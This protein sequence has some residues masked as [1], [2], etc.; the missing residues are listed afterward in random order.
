VEGWLSCGA[1]LAKKNELCG[2]TFMLKGDKTRLR[3]AIPRG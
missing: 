2:L 3:V 1:G